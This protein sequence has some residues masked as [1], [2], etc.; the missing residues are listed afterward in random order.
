MD[1]SRFDTEEIP[2]ELP[3]PFPNP[4]PTKYEADMTIAQLF[5]HFGQECKLEI[6]T[7]EKS[8]T[9]FTDVVLVVI[10]EIVKDD[11][12]VREKMGRISNKMKSIVSMIE[13]LGVQNT[14][15]HI[16]SARNSPAVFEKDFNWNKLPEYIDYTPRHYCD[17]LRIDISVAMKY[18]ADNLSNSKTLILVAAESMASLVNFDIND[19]FQ[20]HSFVYFADYLS[21]L[22]IISSTK[23][24][25]YRINDECFKNMSEKNE[26]QIHLPN[27]NIISKFGEVCFV[28]NQNLTKKIDQL[29]EMMEDFTFKV[30]LGKTATE[31][32]IL[33]DLSSD[34]IKCLRENKY[35]FWRNQYGSYLITPHNQR[36]VIAPEQVPDFFPCKFTS[37]NK[38][39]TVVDGDVSYKMEQKENQFRNPLF[40]SILK[41]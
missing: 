39:Y 19:S 34:V 17:D 4:Y 2:A 22:H 35:C 38:N 8:H 32:L 29:M 18:V 27:T 21:D 11:F 16:I 40:R 14:K 28:G 31:E 13:Q 5:N 1:L 33:G 30:I 24:Q 20:N 9:T 6:K 37:D 12:I 3:N 7:N 26:M 41:I 36:C 10:S 25:M 15:L 23:R